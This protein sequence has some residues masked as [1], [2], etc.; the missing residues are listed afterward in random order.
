MEQVVVTGAHCLPR[1]PEPCSARFT[2]EVTYQRILGGLLDREPIVSAECLFVDPIAD[3]AVIGKP[4]YEL[5][6]EEA[7]RYQELMSQAT[8][9]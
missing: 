7:Q 4:D 8:N 6:G 2:E 5:F 3:I 1:L 9:L